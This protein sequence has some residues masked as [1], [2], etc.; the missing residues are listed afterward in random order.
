M[1]ESIRHAR[2]LPYP[3]MMTF[4]RGMSFAVPENGEFDC[5]R[6]I[7]ARLHACDEQLELIASGQMKLPLGATPATKKGSRKC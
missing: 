2:T 7:Y 3:A 4:L 6:S 1:A 5:V